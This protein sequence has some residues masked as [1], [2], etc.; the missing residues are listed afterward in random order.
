MPAV[1][2]YES[3]IVSLG[4]TLNT[5]DEGTKRAAYEAAEAYVAERCTWSVGAGSDPA[6]ASLVQAVRL[7]TSRYLARRNSPDG[8]AGGGDLGP[9]RVA[10]V[11]RDVD[12]LIAPWRNVVLA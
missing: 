8:L 1:T 9:V 4:P 7:L 5:V 10:A 6:P 2:Q 12:R 11:D 3:L